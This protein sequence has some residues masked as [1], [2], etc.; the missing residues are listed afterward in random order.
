MIPGLVD[1]PVAASIVVAT[2]PLFIAALT[3]LVTW[4]ACRWW[5]VHR[6]A[7]LRRQLESLL[8][9]VSAGAE[10]S[11][12]QPGR[13]ETQRSTAGPSV[14]QLE[15]AL[16]EAEGELQ[17]GRPFLDTSP[18]PHEVVVAMPLS[19][20]ADKAP[21]GINTTQDDA[22]QLNLPST[23]SRKRFA[24][25]NRIGGTMPDH[26]DAFTPLDPGRITSM[27]P[28]ELRHWCKEFGCTEAELRNAIAVAG[29]HVTA[30]R[31]QLALGSGRHRRSG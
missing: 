3:A 28:I 22:M 20:T 18:L 30:V 23:S 25:L 9:R 2:H 1:F 6:L 24:S 21:S 16:D 14:D 27:D 19:A 10:L 8:P 7:K 15:R 13:T 31:D 4:I 12:A 26:H 5:Y 29:E 17:L 11:P